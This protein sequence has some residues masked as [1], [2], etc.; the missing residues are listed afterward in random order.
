MTDISANDD[1]GRMRICDD[2]MR[3]RSRDFEVAINVST[4]NVKVT[5]VTKLDSCH[6]TTILVIAYQI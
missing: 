3:R 2:Y 1:M 4:T 5:K 6:S